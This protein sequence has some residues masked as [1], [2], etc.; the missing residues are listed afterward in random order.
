M[1]TICLVKQIPRPDR[2]EFDQETK[3]LKREGVPLILNPFDARAVAEAVRLRE[4]VGGEVVAMTMGPPQAEEA[5]RVCLALGADRCVHLSDRLFAVADTLG[6]SRT[7][8]MAI[9]KEGVDLVVCGKKTL[10]SETWQVPPEVAAFLGW[11]Q[12]TNV[13]ALERAG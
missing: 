4:A 3:S 2:I 6:T 9:Q 8:A 13:T 12:A 1:K 10:D 7:L 5:L 11:G